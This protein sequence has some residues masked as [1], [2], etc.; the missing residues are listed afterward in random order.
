MVGY[1]GGGA[2]D[3]APESL[4]WSIM[5]VQHTSRSVVN[6]TVMTLWRKTPRVGSCA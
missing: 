5:S 1:V 6:W 4:D 3:E 2:E